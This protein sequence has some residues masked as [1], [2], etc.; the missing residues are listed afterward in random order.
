MQ[1]LTDVAEPGKGA[2]TLAGKGAGAKMAALLGIG[3]PIRGNY[4]KVDIPITVSN[5]AGE[6]F[7][8]SANLTDIPGKKVAKLDRLGKLEGMEMVP[9]G[10]YGKRISAQSETSNLLG[11]KGLRKVID[12]IGEYL[13][14]K[15]FAAH[16]R[17]GGVKGMG[18]GG[19][20]SVGMDLVAAREGRPIK[21]V[22]MRRY[23]TD[24]RPLTSREKEFKKLVGYEH[25]DVYD[26]NFNELDDEL[27]DMGDEAFDAFLMDPGDVGGD[28][29]DLVSG[30]EQLFGLGRK[31]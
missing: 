1:T 16:M 17:G 30:L 9:V 20:P 27:M 24:A 4:H 3:M 25:P 18:S 28:P 7:H 15:E 5:K 14:D 26:Y 21:D 19:D 2:A 23:G 8:T 31:R 12:Y 6:V 29:V 10:K 22:I 13:P 11:H